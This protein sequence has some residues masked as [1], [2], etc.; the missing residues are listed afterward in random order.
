MLIASLGLDQDSCEPRLLTC[1]DRCKRT[2][3]KHFRSRHRQILDSDDCPTGFSH[4]IEIHHCI[5]LK[6]CH[7]QGLHR[8]LAHKSKCTLRAYQRVK[9]Y[10]N[11]VRK[12][13]KRKNIQSRDILDRILMPDTVYKFRI[14]QDV[15]SEFLYLGDK[16]RMGLYELITGFRVRS[17]KDRSVN[18]YNPCINQ[19]PVTVG[20]CTTAHTGSIV[21]HDSTDHTALYGS[22][23]RTKFSIKWLKIIIDLRSDDS[24]L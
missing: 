8:D 7:R 10:I 17:V 18:K 23:I 1:I 24:R 13:Y 5:C 9:D 12:G 15:I 2:L 6:R 19:C 11:R 16:L 21:H 20:M 22:R 14:R 4:I 3:V